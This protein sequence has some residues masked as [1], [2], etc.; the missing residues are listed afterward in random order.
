MFNPKLIGVSF[1]WTVVEYR[2]WISNS[3]VYHWKSFDL[4]FFPLHLEF[5]LLSS[6][7]RNCW[8]S[9]LKQAAQSTFLINHCCIKP[10]IFLTQ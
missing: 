6:P 1:T 9:N 4:N 7:P 5:F 8:N 10:C 2:G 3:L